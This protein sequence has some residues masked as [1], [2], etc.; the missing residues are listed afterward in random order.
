MSSNA[1]QLA[2]LYAAAGADRAWLDEFAEV[3][4]TEPLSPALRWA[5]TTISATGLLGEL[6]DTTKRIS[7]LVGAVSSYSQLDRTSLRKVDVHEGLDSTLAML[8]VKLARVAVE[9]SFAPD[10]VEIDGYG[11]E[12]NQVWTNLIDNAIDAMD[13]E[14]TLRLATRL[15][16]AHIVVDIADSGGGMPADVQARVFEPFFTTKDVGK[17]TGLGLDISRRIVVDRHHGD[18]TFDSKPG[19]TTATVRLPVAHP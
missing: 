13:G 3:V 6:T 17:G 14:G 8:S 11:A 5:S 18:I 1:W 10:L 9:R 2:P 12:L 19:S 4:G 16:G 7:N 15:D